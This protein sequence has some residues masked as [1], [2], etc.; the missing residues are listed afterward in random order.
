MDRVFECLPCQG[1][2]GDSPD[3]PGWRSRR[4]KAATLGSAEELEG[5]AFKV[6]GLGDAGYDRV[7]RTLTEDGDAA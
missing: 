7:I 4:S 3:E 5:E 6:F 1:G 2:S